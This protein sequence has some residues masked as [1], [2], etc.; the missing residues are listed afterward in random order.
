MIYVWN[1]G[2]IITLTSLISKTLSSKFYF[3]TFRSINGVKEPSPW[4]HASPDINGKRL[5]YVKG[6]GRETPW[7][8]KT[9]QWDQENAIYAFLPHLWLEK[10]YFVLEI[11][12][13]GKQMLDN[14]GILQKINNLRNVIIFLKAKGVY[15]VQENAIIR[16]IFSTSQTGKPRHRE[17]SSQAPQWEYRAET[18]GSTVH[19]HLLWGRVFSNLCCPIRQ[20]LATCGYWALEMWLG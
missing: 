3:K 17:N 8:H 7:R 19:L 2:Q 15:T 16:V 9:A 14:K 20:P 1:C 4:Q 13:R 11:K 10:K 12:L 6:K 18:L 5:A